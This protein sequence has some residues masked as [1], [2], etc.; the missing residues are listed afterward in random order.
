MMR[1]ATTDLGR[2]FGRVLAPSDLTRSRA[3]VTAPTSG[4]RVRIGG[5]VAVA[6]PDEVRVADA[7][8]EVAV[9]LDVARELAPGSLVVVEG[10]LDGGRLRDAIVISERSLADP[11]RGG[12]HARLAW[13]GVGR[14]LRARSE[15]LAIVRG[16]FAHEGF[17]EVQTPVRVRTP[18]LEP[19]VDAIAAAGGWLATSPELF[20]KR[21]LVGGL[22]RVYQIAP[23]F[24]ADEVGTWHEPEF[25]LVEWYRAF[26]EYDAILHDTEQLVFA[27]VR[28]LR[29]EPKLRGPEGQVVDVT[30]PFERLTVRE[31]FRRYADGHD[32]AEL[33]ALE[34]ERYFDLLIDRVEPALR[35]R[36]HPVFLV[37]Y[38]IA[39]AALAR[40]TPHDPGVAER[41]ELYLAGVELANGFGELVDPTE[42]RRRFDH[43]LGR[44]AA[45]GLPKYPLDEQFLAALEEGMPPSAGNALGLDRLVALAVEAPGVAAVQAFPE[46]WR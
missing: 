4:E 2:T 30:P 7:L 6:S 17:V 19:N 28:A 12:E 1:R 46:A 18:A 16:H 36:S 24:R 33:A 8:G 27:V 3:G 32:A 42:Q 21:L 15:A 38:P 14:R 40:A 37:E 43:E 9:V 11:V 23:A 13:D 5:R 22:P 44:R 35:R 20:M 31:A 25:T 39:E 41:F 10:H 45:A 26:A 34:P 29:G